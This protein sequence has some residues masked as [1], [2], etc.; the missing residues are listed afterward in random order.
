MNANQR[1]DLVLGLSKRLM[2]TYAAELVARALRHYESSYW[3][4]CRKQALRHDLETLLKG[5][6]RH[7]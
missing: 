7:A 3:Y 2:M 4:S 1:S 5:E 6:I